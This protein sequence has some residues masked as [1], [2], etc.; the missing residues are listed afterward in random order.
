MFLKRSTEFLS[1]NQFYVLIAVSVIIHSLAIS[2]SPQAK[3]LISQLGIRNSSVRAP[4]GDIVEIELVDNTPPEAKKAD[5]SSKKD[6]EQGKKEEA[7]KYKIFTDTSDITADEDNKEDSDKIGEKAAV[8]KDLFPDDGKPVNNKPHAEGHSQAPLLGKGG[9]PSPVNERQQQPQKEENKPQPEQAEGNASKNTPPRYANL[10]KGISQPQQ[11]GSPNKPQPPQQQAPT[12]KSA[13]VIAEMEE[14]AL[15]AVSSPEKPPQTPGRARLVIGQE[16][17][18]EEVMETLPNN[19][20]VFITKERAGIEK[21]PKE[22]EE[23]PA[24]PSQEIKTEEKK[25]AKAEKPREV[26]KEMNAPPVKMEPPAKASELPGYEPS[27]KEER[28]LDEEDNLGEIAKP[29]VFFNVNAKPEGTGKDPVLFEDTISNAAI[30]GAPTFNVKK[31]EYADY[32]K[33]IRDRISLY[34]FLGYGTRAEIKL[35]TKDDKPII[36]EFKVY[37][38]GAIDD[39]KIVDD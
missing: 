25:M 32:F 33:H 29:K 10:P 20:A 21:I 12:V 14:A 28:G 3:H 37:P 13:E 4:G 2:L 9:A 1:K 39:V 11:T 38:N 35:E 31:H 36:I 30:P 15:D 17:E 34:W 18:D 27:R 7:K 5:T 19:D 16:V 6:E 23:K 26:M 22:P 8:A 24:P